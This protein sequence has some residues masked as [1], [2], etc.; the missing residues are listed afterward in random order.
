[1][2]EFDNRV[3]VS[4]ERQWVNFPSL[5]LFRQHRVAHDVERV[6]FETAYTAGDDLV[7]GIVIVCAALTGQSEDQMGA[8]FEPMGV[9]AVHRRGEVGECMPPVD[10]SEGL[11]VG[12]LQTQ[13]DQDVGAF[14]AQFREQCE[15]A[16]VQTVGPGAYGQ[17]DN[18]WGGQGLT[19]GTL[20]NIV[21]GISI[22]VS[23]KIDHVTA[24]SL[25]F[26]DLLASCTNLLGQRLAAVGRVGGKGAVVAEGASA[27]PFDAVAVG[28][29]QLGVHRYFVNALA[30]FAK[31]LGAVGVDV[32]GE[33]HGV[34]LSDRR[35]EPGRG[36]RKVNHD[37]DSVRDGRNQGAAGG[38]G[39]H[40]EK[41]EDKR[42]GEANKAA[43]ENHQHHS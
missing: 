30:V 35:C 1:M 7:Q 17:P 36:D 19:V 3:G 12:G 38:S 18:P 11:I 39:V 27:G 6:E 14:I 37:A 23:L 22:R 33:L 29:G 26:L 2:N 32:I 43:E 41:A 25:I 10:L 5:K 13:F 20:E 16:R 40:A 31:K 8:G 24:R 28:A 21:L 4:F 34:V 42:H 15:C 9:N